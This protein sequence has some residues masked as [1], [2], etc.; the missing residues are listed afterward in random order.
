MRVTGDLTDKNGEALTE[1]LEMWHRDPVECIKEL[2]EN[3]A[4]VNQQCYEPCRMFKNQNYTN[5][6]YNE[7]WGG[8]WWWNTQVG[9]AVKTTEVSQI[10]I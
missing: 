6:E 4:F 2:M 3:P 1:N 7:M 9:S 8:D 5:R 10:L